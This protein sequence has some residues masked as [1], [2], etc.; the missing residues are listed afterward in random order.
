MK[1]K[2]N[3]NENTT[4]ETEKN[5][6][7]NQW[8]II[9]KKN[10]K[11]NNFYVYALIDPTTNLPFYIGKG[12]NNRDKSHITEVKNNK[13][14]HGNKRLFYTIKNIVNN[15]LNV[16][17]KHLESNLSEQDAFFKEIEYIKKYGRKDLNT[18]ILTNLTDGGEGQSGWVAPS[19]YRQRM[20]VSTSGNKNGMFGKNHTSESKELIRKKSIGRKYDDSVRKNKSLKMMGQNNHFYGKKH[21]TETI[22]KLKENS[23]KKY[24][25]ENKSYVNLDSVKQLIIDEYNKKTNLSELTRIVNKNGIKCSRVA[26][27]RRLIEWNLIL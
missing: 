2:K 26:I 8:S 19:D 3:G 6:T 23:T 13:I 4:I 16:I 7:N 18:G 22:L 27:K 10:I 5:L 15:N 9:T 14:P 17:I 21:T 12:K 1:P 20:S 11:Q 25:Y 24:K